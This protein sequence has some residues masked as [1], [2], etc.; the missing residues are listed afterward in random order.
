MN[1]QTDN[2]TRARLSECY[3]GY[4]LTQDQPYDHLRHDTYHDHLYREDT[5]QITTTTTLRNWDQFREAM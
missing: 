5:D 2:L 3:G 1:N 4:S